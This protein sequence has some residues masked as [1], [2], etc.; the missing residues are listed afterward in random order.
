MRSGSISDSVILRR[1]LPGKV[2][3]KRGSSEHLLGLRVRVVGL[4]FTLFKGSTIGATRGRKVTPRPHPLSRALQGFKQLRMVHG[5]SRIA[6]CHRRIFYNWILYTSDANPPFR[7]LLFETVL[8][9]RTLRASQRPHVWFINV[10]E[11]ILCF[12]QFHWPFLAL[13]SFPESTIFPLD[14]S[15]WNFFRPFRFIA[16]KHVALLTELV[17]TDRGLRLFRLASTRSE[18]SRNRYFLEYLFS[19]NRVE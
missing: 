3:G 8:E 2:A 19:V 12:F 5:S 13:G 18:N 14:R 9:T 11:T 10:L 6:Q 15:V 1:F 7:H 17:S 4:N 16:F